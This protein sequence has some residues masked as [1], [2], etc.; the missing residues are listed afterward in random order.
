M[1]P[2]FGQAGTC[3][4]SMLGSRPVLGRGPAARVRAPNPQPTTL[5]GTS[6]VAFLPSTLDQSLEFFAYG[7]DQSRVSPRVVE[8][9]VDITAFVQSDLEWVENALFAATH[10]GVAPATDAARHLVVRGGK[11][12]RPL[13]ALL[14]SACFA[15][16]GEQARTV[17]LIAELIHTATLLHDDVADEGRE[18]RGALAARLVY[19]NAVSVL[20][21]DLLLVHALERAS[22]DLPEHLPSLL[23]TM[24]D[25]VDGEVLQLRGRT[26][27]DVSSETYERILRGKTASLFAWA[28]RCGALVG[29]ASEA[30][31]AL[32]GEFGQTLGFAF[33]LVDDLLDYAGSNTGKTSLVDLCE[34]KLTLPLV[35]A[36]ERVPSLVPRI[37]RIHGGDLEEVAAV[38]EAVIRSG[39]CDEVRARARAVTRRAVTLLESIPPSRS[40]ELLCAVALELSARVD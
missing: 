37:A 19:G 12:V 28:T 21:G 20:G 15:P 36:A 23:G 38:G 8:R 35:L 40:R 9:L 27:F 1:G 17:A 31:A 2:G 34:G 32:L 29:H 13:A 39:A 6:G 4:G 18:R 22:Q 16:L 24:R 14:S 25:L 10:E 30:N 33:Q 7:A 5:G 3:E 11:R 26:K